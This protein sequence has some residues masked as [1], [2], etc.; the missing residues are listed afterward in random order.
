M[1]QRGDSV[2]FDE[3]VAG[4]LKFGSLVRERRE[5]AALSR[6]QLAER[7]GCSEQSIEHVEKFG[8][9]PSLERMIALFKAT[10]RDD[11]DFWL[12]EP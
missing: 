12:D 7:M 1:A 9:D 8:L 11:E 10:E 2:T 4:A 6:A 5:A 3:D